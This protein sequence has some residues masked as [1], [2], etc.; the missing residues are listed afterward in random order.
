MVF[1]WLGA[2]KG[3]RMKESGARIQELGGARV[4]LRVVC[5][6]HFVPKSNQ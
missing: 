6:N 2:K 3:V 4:G 5:D 1:G